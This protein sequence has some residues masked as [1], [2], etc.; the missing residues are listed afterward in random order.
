MHVHVHVINTTDC[1]DSCRASLNRW[2]RN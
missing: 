2:K 1:D